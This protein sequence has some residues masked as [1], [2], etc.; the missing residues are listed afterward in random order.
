MAADIT[1]S[2]AVR[3]NLLSL[4]NTADLLGRTQERLAT[5]L[6]VNSALDDPTA[7]FTAASLTSRA[8]DLNRLLDSVGNAVQTIQAADNGIEAITKLV[9]NAQAT[10][11]QARQASIGST[12]ATT[13]T[14]T[15]VIAADSAAVNAGTGQSFAGTETLQSLGFSNGETITITTDA[16]TTTHTIADASTEDVDDVITSLTANAEAGV[17]LNGG[18]VVATASNNT[19]SITFGGTGDVTQLGLTT[20]AAGPTN[21]QVAGFTG[22]LSVQ[23]NSATAETIDLSTINTRAA[24]ETALGG[25]T[26]VTASVNGSNFVEITALANTDAL[27]ISGGSEVGLTDGTTNAPYSSERSSLETSFNDLRTQIDQLAADASFNGINLLNGDSL[28]VIFNEDGSSSLSVTGVTFNSTGLGISTATADSFQTNGAIDA[29][30]SELDSAI[31]TLRQQASTFGSNLSVVEIRQ[32]FTE[33]LINTLETGAGNLTLADANEEG[34]NLLA[35]QTRQQLAS[36]SLS[37]A[38]QA[39]QNVLRLF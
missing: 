11:R 18:N 10:A 22:T 34:A 28:S 2:S 38:S 1:L 14:G 4:Q 25:L 8:N 26:G 5:G 20:T 12:T 21:A 17:A 24:L 6:K 19:T 29:A 33:N 13:L 35:L 30:L 31:A 7:F 27:T 23:V 9:E 39:D 16:G 15:V 37:L 36:V 32:D 3:N